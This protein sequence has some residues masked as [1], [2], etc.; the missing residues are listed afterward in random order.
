MSGG[1]GEYVNNSEEITG[2]NGSPIDRTL[3][4]KNS[5]K[6]IATI[7]GV[8]AMANKGSN[9]NA[10]KLYL[11]DPYQYLPKPG[12]Y[13]V[14]SQDG[15]VRN[16]TNAGLEY[17]TDL[18]LYIT[19]IEFSPPVSEL[20]EGQAYI[21]KNVLNLTPDYSI[22]PRSIAV[23]NGTDISDVISQLQVQYPDYD[24]NKDINGNPRVS[25][26]KIDVGPYEYNS[27]ISGM[28]QPAIQ[29]TSVLSKIANFLTG[30]A[31]LTG[32][33]TGV[34]ENGAGYVGFIV[35]V[36]VVVL[37]LIILFVVRSRKGKARKEKIKIA[38][39][40]L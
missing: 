37:L 15:I 9:M 20:K 2:I 11:Y 12:D 40:K 6:T 1:Y 10:T 14:L 35:L 28:S 4:F 16:I 18:W 26:G 27:G 22:G 31:V 7:Q 23:D 34:N 19:K 17:S 13:L 39:K 33:V 5:P 25:N 24:F 36:L 32:N 38:K 30:N 29:S 8:A 3:V 21:W